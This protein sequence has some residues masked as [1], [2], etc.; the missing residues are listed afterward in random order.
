MNSLFQQLNPNG[1]FSQNP[2]VQLFKMA[3]KSNNPQQF[4]TELAK[5]NSK[6]KQMLELIDSSGKSP[7][8]LFYQMAK[9]KGV[10]PN[11]I[12]NMLK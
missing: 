9:Q 1:S 2:I 6:T 3:Q 7:K 11:Q 4:I 10:D 5:N 12:L 8:D